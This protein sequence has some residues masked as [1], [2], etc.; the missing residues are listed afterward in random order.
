VKWL[1]ESVSCENIVLWRGH[2]TASGSE[3]SVNLTINGG[4]AFA[5]SIWLNDV[6]I[7]TAFGK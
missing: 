4:Q 5:A 1:K 6:F 2:F 7:G 3:T